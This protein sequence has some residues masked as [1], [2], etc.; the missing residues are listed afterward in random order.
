M[1]KVKVALVLGGGAARGLAHLGVLKIL[2]QSGI[3]IDM[4]VGTSMGSLVGAMYLMRGRVGKILPDLTRFLNSEDF[5]QSRIHS[6]KRGE[7]EDIG[8]FDQ[9]SKYLKRAQVVSS[10][11]TRK[12][13]FSD[14][15]IRD[16]FS[17]F[18]DDRDIRELKIPFCAVATDL[19]TGEEVL[20]KSG[21]VLD[22]VSASSAIPGA[23]PPIQIGERVCIDGGIVNMVPVT[24]AIRMGA[25]FVIAV[26]VSHELPRPSEYKR[27]LEIY[28]RA[29]EITKRALISHQIQ[30][31]DIVLTPNVGDIHWAD[32]TRPDELIEAGEKIAKEKEPAIWAMLQKMRRIPKIFRRRKARLIDLIP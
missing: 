8:L 3:P 30:F 24:V 28:F 13:Y 2:E 23:F 5:A 22:A 21:S 11:V 1:A 25:D 15:E 26:N 29:H 31:A 10:T 27:A 14:D 20:I 16:F 12:A 7:T 17:H 4:I 18:V 19:L 32:F 6:L 9:F